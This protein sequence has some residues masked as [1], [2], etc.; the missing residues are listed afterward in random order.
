MYIL[1]N[2]FILIQSKQMKI[3]IGWINYNSTDQ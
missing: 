1:A 2:K 3:R